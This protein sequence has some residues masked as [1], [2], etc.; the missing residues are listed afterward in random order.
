MSKKSTY[1]LLILLTIII[2]TILYW[3]LCCNVCCTESM[4]TT[5]E[6]TNTEESLKPTVKD[7]TSIPFRIMDALGKLSYTVDD[8]FNFNTSS[9]SIA[10]PIPVLVQDGVASVADYIKTNPNK[11]IAITGYYKSDEKNTSSYENLGIARAEAVK[12]YMVEKGVPAEI[13]ETFGKLND[14][15]IPDQNGILYGPV[16]FD[17]ETLNTESSA[18]TTKM[19]I[20]EEFRKKPLLIYFNIGQ[21]TTGINT[22]QKEKLKAIASC[23][24]TPNATVRIIGNTD[25]TGSD[26]LNNNLGQARANFGKNYLIKQGVSAD[27]I[28]TSS[29]GE[30]S[31]V[32]SN[33]NA[34]GRAKN[35]RIE[36]IIK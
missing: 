4:N 12:K 28:S 18:D 17:M 26:D 20:C 14:A 34:K 33:E 32:A 35:R 8:N 16:K 5:E 10:D 13:M 27:K 25:N 29:N 36:I 30:N 2:G 15:M 6:T 1:L 11:K 3:F 21:S 23:L 19:A 22:S 9:A 7:P 31:P 24:Q